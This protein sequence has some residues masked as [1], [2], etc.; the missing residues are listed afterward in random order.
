VDTLLASTVM[1]VAGVSVL[2]AFTLR[3]WSRAYQ[4]R[5]NDMRERMLTYER[6]IVE[7][8]KMISDMQVA[9]DNLYGK[10]EVQRNRET[11]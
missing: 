2:I 8:E 9:F 1:V 6:R 10:V 5:F 4:T 7:M 11:T 3:M